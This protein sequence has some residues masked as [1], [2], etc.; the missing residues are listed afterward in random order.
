MM[1]FK[2]EYDF[3][4]GLT[5]LENEDL[6]MFQ[7]RDIKTDWMSKDDRFISKITLPNL[8]KDRLDDHLSYELNIKNRY[9]SGINFLNHEKYS[10]AVECFDDVIY[11]N[12]DSNALMGKSHALFGQKHFVKALRYYRKAIALNS[13]LKDNSYY[14]L[15]LDNS[16]AE[17]DNF[18]KLKLNIYAG[19]EFFS[20]GEF[21]KALKSYDKALANPSKFKQKIL[22]KLLN[23]K[24]TTYVQLNDFENAKLCFNESLNV[25]NNDY[26]CFGLGY[27][28]YKLNQDL[29]PCFKKSLKIT[30]QEL[31]VK[32][33]ILSKSGYETESRRD[34]EEFLKNHFI[35]DDD[36]RMAMDG[37]AK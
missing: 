14:R 24:A 25:L 32:A 1:T 15:L 10:K 7:F 30:K 26:A 35:I 20:K 8:N 23:K 2:D 21:E 11:Y 28:Q 17:R 19:D 37:L 31:L 36:Y 12:S 22:F 34:Y 16:R 3:P 18:P 27:C 5:V 9:D 33:D 6:V 4:D 13:S 29:S